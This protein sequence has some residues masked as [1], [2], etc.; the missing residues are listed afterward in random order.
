MRRFVAEGRNFLF[1]SGAIRAFLLRMQQNEGPDLANGVD[2][3]TYYVRKRNALVARGEFTSLFV[4]FYLHLA[5]IDSRPPS[6]LSDMFTEML[7]A[8]TLHCASRPRNETLAWTLH[9]KDP[10]VNLFLSGN[11]AQSSVIGSIH[12][13]HVR[14]GMENIF[15]A[16][17]VRGTGPSRRSVVN[18]EGNSSFSAVEQ[19]Y[20][21]SEQ[22]PTKF[23]RFQD[24]DI[25][26]V[27]AQPDCDVEWLESLDVEKIRELDRVESLSLLECRSYCWC[28]G[29]SE[30]RILQLLGPSMRNDPEK[31][32]EGEEV[33][34]VGCP[35]C[36]ARYVVTREALEAHVANH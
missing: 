10:M 9:F 19:F 26:M 32:F 5:S 20:A 18:F 2:V 35:R 3:R 33:I 21:Q 25:V 17:V 15:F 28:C 6:L 13:D 11:N 23:L 4:D 27:S 16:D 8:L 36:G 30:T 34:R 29:C 7:A 31:L 22:R 24:N 1:E 14:E 12:T